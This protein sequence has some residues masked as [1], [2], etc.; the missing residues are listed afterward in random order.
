MPLTKLSLSL[1]ACA[2]AVLCA[3]A[4]SQ[5][6]NLTVKGAV[7]IGQTG[8]PG[9]IWHK[10]NSVSQNMIFSANVDG[11]LHI[12]P[13]G[14]DAAGNGFNVVHIGAGAPAMTLY[15]RGSVV[16]TSDARL[17][18]NVTTLEHVLD[19]VL[20]LRGVRYDMIEQKD[21]TPGRGRQLGFLAQE[22]EQ[23]FPEL[24]YTDSRG[25][26]AV[27]YDRVTALLVA[28][29][30]EQHSRTDAEI[31]SLRRDL[32]AL[33]A[34]QASLGSG[35]SGGGATRAGFAMP[36]LAALLLGVGV[37]LLLRRARAKGRG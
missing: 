33:A 14:R 22:L 35:E 28:A 27:A 17:K 11:T 12:A 23:A 5:A 36:S 7:K 13:Y 37:G 19:K 3:S 18:Q 9:Q 15:V 24:V 26:K 25:Y 29:L 4:S 32:K 30:K 6:Q 16:S 10:D 2:V 20:A 1:T 34:A 8:Q 31:A 21:V